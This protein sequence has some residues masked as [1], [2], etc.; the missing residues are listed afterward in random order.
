MNFSKKN[1]TEKK[2]QLK[3]DALIDTMKNTGFL[4]DNRVESAIQKVPRHNFVPESLKN[5]AYENS[6]LP[7]IEKQTISQPSVVSRM[8]EWL[9]LKEGQKVLEIGSGSGWQSA[10]LANI[11]GNGKIFT[12]ER[13]AKLAN[14]A[15]KNLE[16]LGIKNVT[17]IH[18]DG[19]LGLP[20]E[21]PFDR[22][23]ITAACK[24]IPNILLH[25]LSL[26]GLLI[27]PVGDD[28][29]SLILLKKTSKGFVEIKNQKGYVFVPLL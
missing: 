16:K 13:H 10:I 11:V 18:G 15:K 14:F 27:A 26:D 23:M 21:S 19:N 3:L 1:N 2:Y 12:V 28:I 17:I 4:T 7:I 22:I 6:P 29:Q 5:R 8:T 9:D 20:E 25:Q 24:K